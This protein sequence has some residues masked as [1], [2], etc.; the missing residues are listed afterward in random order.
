MPRG[1]AARAHDQTALLVLVRDARLR[2]RRRRPLALR[3]DGRLVL[4]LALGLVAVVRR[5]R[6]GRRARARLGLRFLGV[7][8]LRRRELGAHRGH[9]ALVVVLVRRVLAERARA[10]RAAWAAAAFL[11]F[12]AFFLLIAIL[13]SEL[14]YFLCDLFSE[15][16]SYRLHYSAE[17]LMLACC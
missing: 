4:A 11:S 10:A 9:L 15:E 2:G 16:L 5:R 17:L 7:R 13:L 6:R 8:V 1:G 3:A 12:R 14:Y